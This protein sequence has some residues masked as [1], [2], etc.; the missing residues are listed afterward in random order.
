M[1]DER[2]YRPF[3]IIPNRE[4]LPDF[5]RIVPQYFQSL[6]RKMKYLNEQGF[7]PILETIRRDVGPPWKADFNFDESYSRFVQY[8]VARYGAYNFIFSKVHFDIYLKNLSLTADEFNE[9]LN[10]HFH[11]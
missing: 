3:E 11:K 8:M 10:Y 9:A 7:T 2:G 5:N 1:H 4:G 6:D